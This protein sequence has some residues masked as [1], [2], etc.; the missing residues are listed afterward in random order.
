M[1]Y[2]VLQVGP[3]GEDLQQDHNLV[4]IALQRLVDK[5]QQVQHVVRVVLQVG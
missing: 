2:L 1:L 4:A 5:A 3:M